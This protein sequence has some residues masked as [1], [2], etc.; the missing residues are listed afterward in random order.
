MLDSIAISNK[1]KDINF[2][3]DESNKIAKEVTEA[4]QKHGIINRR[5]LDGEVYAYETDGYG[6]AYFMDDANIPSLLS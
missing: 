1:D 6:S 5:D 4:I 2:I 3:R